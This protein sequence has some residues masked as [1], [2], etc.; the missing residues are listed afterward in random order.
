LDLSERGVIV[1][2]GLDNIIR[3]RLA[4]DSPDGLRGVGQSIAG[5]SRPDSFPEGADG[6]Y[7]RA[8]VVDGVQRVLHYR[9]IGSYP[10]VATVGLDLDNALAPVRTHATVVGGFTLIA[11]LLLI[12][13]AAFLIRA[14]R[15]QAANE[16]ELR[17]LEQ[18]Q[19]DLERQL[20]RTQKLEA[21]GTLAGGIAHDLN[22][23]LVP[24]LTL[25][26]LVRQRLPETSAERRDLE[27][28]VQA[29]R[30]GRELVRQ[31]LAFSRNQEP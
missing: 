25:S 22:N 29:S 8:G 3:A 12:G 10:L 14:I 23:T 20:F 16:L 7:L 31:V 19:R 18:S 5:D 17:S 24:I 26:E 13:L 30:R 11:S 4:A 6:D 15:R 2:T 28:V 21:L 9:R 27:I 1:L